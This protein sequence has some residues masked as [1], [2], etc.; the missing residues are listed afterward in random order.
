LNTSSALP[1][2]SLVLGNR[3]FFFK[4]AIVVVDIYSLPFSN[5][6]PVD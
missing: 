5:M 2:I 4:N 6:R 3:K 1:R